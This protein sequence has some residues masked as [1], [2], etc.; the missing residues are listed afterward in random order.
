MIHFLGLWVKDLCPLLKLPILGVLWIFVCLA[1]YVFYKVCFL[2]I[3]NSWT[4]KI[5]FSHLVF[6]LLPDWSH[7]NGE[8]RL[9]RYQNWMQLKFNC[10][11]NFS[12]MP[13]LAAAMASWSYTT[14]WIS[15]PSTSFSMLSPSLRTTFHRPSSK[16]SL[17]VSKSNR[18][19][20]W[21]LRRQR[22]MFQRRVSS[23]MTQPKLGNFCSASRLSRPVL[24]RLWRFLLCCFVLCRNTLP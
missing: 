23:S 3:S 15:I 24:I 2:K 8:R 10:F 7:V 11:R 5:H 17:P 4:V 21:P 19:E 22:L 1:F 16:A 9:F 13:K 14:D 20:F 18:R 12:P 6:T